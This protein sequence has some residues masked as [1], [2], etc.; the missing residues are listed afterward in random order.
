VRNLTNA[1]RVI[2]NMLVDLRSAD[3]TTPDEPTILA[4]C[5]AALVDREGGSQDDLAWIRRTFRG[6]WA[7]ETRASRNWIARGSLGPLGFA[8]YGQHSIYY[9]W[10]ESVWNRSDV[11]IFGPMGVDP[12]LRGMRLGVVLA[13]RA[14]RSLKA[15]G[16]AEA[17]IPAAGPLEFYEKHCGAR[18]VERLSRPA[19]P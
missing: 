12:K 7:D 16:Y 14:L 4:A 10:L 3:F 6:K 17:I 13:R 15:A 18:V 1:I 8:S 2:V 5:G 11:G 19:T 9:W